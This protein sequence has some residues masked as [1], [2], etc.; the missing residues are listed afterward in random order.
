MV[1]VGQ[2]ADATFIKEALKA[3][4][5][6]RSLHPGTPSLTNSQSVFYIE[7]DFK[8]VIYKPITFCLFNQ[9]NDKA[10]KWAQYLAAIDKSKHSGG[11]E[12]GE[13]IYTGYAVNN[14]KKAVDSWYSEIKNTISN[15]LVTAIALVHDIP[16][17]IYILIKKRIYF[18]SFHP[19]SLGRDP[20]IRYEDSNMDKNEIEL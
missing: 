6:Y 14:G 17:L 5:Y 11:G 20:T 12:V 19:S 16:L 8:Y 1:K 7:H 15:H 18:R 10:Q 4:N 3:H 2:A 9:L 13:N